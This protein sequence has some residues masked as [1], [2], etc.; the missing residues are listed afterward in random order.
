MKLS[1]YKILPGLFTRNF[2]TDNIIHF[3]ALPWLHFTSVSHARNYNFQDSCPKIS[4]G[5]II[6]HDDEKKIMPVS[7]HVHH[8]LMD[9]YHAGLFF[10]KLHE[11][12]DKD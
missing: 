4:V 7:L 8:A 5:K 9:G 3:S 11:M 1:V 2:E 12:L 10:E 6:T